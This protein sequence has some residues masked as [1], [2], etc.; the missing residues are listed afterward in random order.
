MPKAW[1]QLSTLDWQQIRLAYEND[2][3][4]PTM[5]TLATQY[6]IDNST[7]SK[8]ARAQKWQRKDSLAIATI[9]S[10]KNAN[11]AIVEQTTANVTRHLAQQLTDSLAPWIEREKTRHIKAQVKRSK[12]AL[13]QLDDN[14]LKP[15]IILNPKDSSFVAKTAE[16]WDNIMRRSLGMNDSVPTG[17]GL[18]L[19]VLTNHA[20][21]QV[22]A[23]T[24]ET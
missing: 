22:K 19:N 24:N 5:Q 4:R 16:T 18:T 8:Y 23:N 11:A 12:L 13:K 7:V 21:V 2:P 10:V 3:Q 14:H 9:E 6:G 17:T 15:E 20:A 1:K